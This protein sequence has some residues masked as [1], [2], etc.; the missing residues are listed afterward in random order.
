M[1][2]RVRVRDNAVALHVF[3]EGCERGH[4]LVAVQLVHLHLNVV[5]AHRHYRLLSASNKAHSNIVAIAT[6][7][8]TKE[9]HSDR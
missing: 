3:E 9:P 5:I 2:H 4:A 7:S 1:T 8:H 6:V